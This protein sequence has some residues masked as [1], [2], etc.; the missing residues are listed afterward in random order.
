[1][2]PRT[3]ATR[4]PSPPRTPSTPSRINQMNQSKRRRKRV[5]WRFSNNFSSWEKGRGGI[6]V[7]VVGAVWGT[8]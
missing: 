3:P 4:T 5:G 1:L 2:P 6:W 8:S 7:G